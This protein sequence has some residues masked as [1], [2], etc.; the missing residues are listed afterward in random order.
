MMT[1]T[2]QKLAELAGVSKRTLR[3]YDQIGLLHPAEINANG[4][5]IYTENEVDLLQ[6]ILFLESWMWI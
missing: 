6:Q 2:V 1:Y 3:Y 4:Y 5:R